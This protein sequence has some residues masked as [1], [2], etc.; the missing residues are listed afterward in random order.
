MCG[1]CARTIP[2]A[3]APASSKRAWRGSLLTAVVATR[4]HG[5]AARHYAGRVAHYPRPDLAV[6]I[7]RITMRLIASHTTDQSWPCTLADWA[8]RSVASLP[9]AMA[10]A[11]SARQDSTLGAQVA[12]SA[13]R[14][15]SGRSLETIGRPA[16]A[17]SRSLIGF[18]QRVSSFVRNGT[19][20]A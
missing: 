18:T 7:V 8:R 10:C 20:A 16:A 1:P 5:G 3:R 4:V 6:D 11:S 12:M 14:R 9:R 13:Q 15:T 19:I 2:T 17:Y